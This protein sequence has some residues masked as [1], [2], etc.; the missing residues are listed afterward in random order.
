M[1]VEGGA[2]SPGGGSSDGGD[3]VGVVI[4]AAGSGSRMGGR[5]KQYLELEGVPV[6]LRAVRP[7][8]DRSDVEDVVVVLPPG[9][10][11]APP[12]WLGKADDRIRTVAGGATRADSV[13]AGLEALPGHVP[14]IAIH[15]GARPLVEADVVERCLRVARSGA[16]AVAAFPAVDTMKTVD[17][18]GRILDTPDRD[19]LW[20]AQ[21]PQVFPRTMIL[22]AYRSAGA[23]AAD[24]TDD[25][26]LVERRGETVRVVRSSPRNLKV[27]RPDDMALARFYL[28]T[29][30]G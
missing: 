11:E 20:H 23:H 6:L 1:N 10:A 21:T 9:D 25:A 7:F 29:S 22:E 24:A 18:E 4:P 12:P 3:R 2:A 8:L 30:A 16:G 14:V 13:R 17:G 27:T 19:A 28:R 5:K 26:S 15:D